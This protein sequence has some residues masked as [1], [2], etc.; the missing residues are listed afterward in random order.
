MQTRL[1]TG[2]TMQTAP[3]ALPGFQNI[4]WVACGRRLGQLVCVRQLRTASLWVALP[5]VVVR[6]RPP[7][8]REAGEAAC[9][10]HTGAETLCLLQQPEAVHYTLD[11]VA[12]ASR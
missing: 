5:Q 10:Q 8:D 11:H 6:I 7:S 4:C 3:T 12:G 9:L 2:C 1:L